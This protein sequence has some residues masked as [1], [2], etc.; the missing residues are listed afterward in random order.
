MY[1][2]ILGKD[3]PTLPLSELKSV[4][5]INGSAIISAQDNFVLVDKKFDWKRLALSTLVFRVQ[6][7]GKKPESAADYVA[8][9]GTFAVRI[10]HNKRLEKSIGRELS[11]KAKVDLTKPDETYFGLNKDQFYFGKVLW[12]RPSF[13]G[14]KVQNRPFFHPTS[15]HPKYAR[16]LVNLSE[17][18]KGETLLDP[19]CGTGGILIEAAM[20]GAKAVGFDV[21]KDMVRGTQDNLAFYKLDGDVSH[22]DALRLS[23]QYCAIATD[24]PY[25]RAS[26]VTG[27]KLQQLYD[28][29]LDSMAKVLKPGRKIAIVVPDTV[30]ISPP[31]TLAI[32]E[33]HYQRVHKSLSRYFYVLEN[34]KQGYD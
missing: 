4:L 23:G 28:E 13:E 14:R 3:H 33:K 22:G 32:L 19:F 34:S 29:S 1:G 24:P 18:R 17:V 16:V 9:T 25:G 6:Y 8:P 20:V 26:Y 7:S 10:R 31:K 15:I 27:K 11:K 21:D 30:K 5:A 12:K 2:I